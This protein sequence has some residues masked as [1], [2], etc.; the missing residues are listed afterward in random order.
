VIDLSCRNLSKRYQL[1]HGR[2]EATFWALRDVSF[3]VQRGEAVGVIGHNGAGKSTLLKLLAS[4]TSPTSGEIVISGRLSALIE[5]GSGFHPEL[6]G[7]ENVYLSGAILGMKRREIAD[8]FDRIVE[9][10]GVAPF[11]DVPV[12]RYS[13]GMYVRLG[14]AIAAHLEPDVLLIDE[15]LAVG[16]AAFQRQCLA[17]IQELRKAGTTAVFISHDLAAVEQLCDRALLL[18]HGCIAD[19]GS[20]RQVVGEYRSRL[21][22]HA[23]P[24][25][26]GDAAPT[27]PAVALD[28]V[29]LRDEGGNVEGC[30]TGD[31][32]RV[33]VSYRAA[34]DVE[35]VWAEVFFYSADGRVLHFQQTTALSPRALAVQAGAGCIEFIVDELPLQPGSY[36]VVAAL[37]DST[38]Q[39]VLSWTPG[40]S[41]LVSTGKTV[42]GL[43][44]TPHRWRHVLEPEAESVPR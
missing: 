9:F 8:K 19:S 32:L 29:E 28:S 36:T 16:D 13:S 6:T 4:I 42:R 27:P 39:N 20:P 21:M 40:P 3:D 5:V 25:P 22:V 41:L 17:R 43:F 15:V 35:G 44:Y 12:K 1:R 2:T 37:R 10:A 30:R 33:R 34:A 24:G 26:P 18:E 14:F 38:S 11:I 23:T 31:P 7:R